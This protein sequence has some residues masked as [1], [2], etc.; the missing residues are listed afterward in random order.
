MGRK[1]KDATGKREGER[2]GSVPLTYAVS[3]PSPSG[4]C[5]AFF[6]LN[7]MVIHG[8]TSV[9]C[10]RLLTSISPLSPTQQ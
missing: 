3:S 5:L 4:S 8:G 1:G 6:T 9:P 2:G 10:N 7:S